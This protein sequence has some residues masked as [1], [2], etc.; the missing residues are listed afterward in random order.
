[1]SDL[2][3]ECTNFDF[4][5]DPAL[6][7]LQRSRRSP[8]WPTSKEMEGKRMGKD[9]EEKERRTEARDWREREEWKERGTRGKCEAWGT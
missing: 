1:M 8:K 3:L 7:S 5:P 2:R 6:G 9:G 4:R